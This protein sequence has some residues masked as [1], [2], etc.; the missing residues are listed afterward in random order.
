MKAIAWTLVFL[1][2]A[3]LPP[4][5]QGEQEKEGQEKKK[6]ASAITRF[7]QDETE[8]LTKEIDGSWM[9]VEYTDPEQ[10]DIGD[11]ASGFATFHD[12]YLTLLTS[13]DGVSR[14][15]FR[16]RQQ[17]YLQAG[18]YRYRIDEQT[19]LQLSSVLLFS[20]DNED[21]DLEHHPAGEVFEF[22]VKLEDGVLEL[23]DTTGLLMSFRR[24]TSGEFPEA[25]IRKLDSHRSGTSFWEK[26]D[27]QPR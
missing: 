19:N 26:Q 4:A 22:F 24:V 21:G 3:F 10:M 7:F 14:R 16:Y 11:G 25:A 17:V 27:E 13:V 20:N 23:R 5:R 12:G 8:R 6:S 18:A 1:S 15:L 9:L 2:S